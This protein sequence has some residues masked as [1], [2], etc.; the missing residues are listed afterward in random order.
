MSQLEWR[1]WGSGIRGKE[2]KEGVKDFQLLRCVEIVKWSCEMRHVC[3]EQP[4]AKHQIDKGAC[5]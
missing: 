1:K 5:H 3:S 2:R 4:V